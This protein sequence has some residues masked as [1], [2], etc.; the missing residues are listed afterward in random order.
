MLN[1]KGRRGKL[2]SSGTI[3]VL[4]F[5]SL[6]LVSAAL[7]AQKDPGPRHGAP[8]AGGP[9]LTLS[10][11]ELDSFAQA[12]LRFAR[13]VSV[14]GTIE[15]GRGLG[16]T[17]NGND[18]AMCHQ[19]PTVGGSSTS[20]SS[21]D[22]PH[23]NPQVALATLHG[24]TNSVPP[25]IA[26]KGP[27][28]A[29]RFIRQ[30]DGSP[31]GQVHGMYTIAGRIDAK[32]CDLRQPDFAKQMADNNLALRIPTPLYGLGLVEST[33]DIALRNNL[34]STSGPRSR[35]GIAGTFNLSPQDGSIMRFGWKA[36]NKSLLMFAAE[37]SSVEEGITNELFPNKRDATPGCTFNATPEDSSHL[38]NPNSQSPN[39]GTAAGTTSEM[40]SDIVNFAMFIRLLAPPKPAPPTE[41]MQKG[42]SLFNQIGCGLCHSPSLETGASVYTSLSDVTYHPYSDFAL[43]HMGP[44]LADGISQAM[45]GPDEFRTAPLWG[46]GKRLFFLHDGRTSDL[47]RAIEEHS[48]HTACEQKENGKPEQSCSSEA[49]AVIANFKALAPSEIQDILNFLR[50]L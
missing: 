26:E 30:P 45:A 17:F 44:G 3:I 41:S 18:C 29:A 13:S 49:D 33:P 16:P 39:V 48:S 6:A 1:K 20:P 15:K 19:Q 24:A 35:L 7:Q 4:L 47:L 28:F 46:I 40:S 12:F 2:K 21:P 14:S 37:A 25:F 22:E 27:T 36:Q 34:E 32:G 11:S 23:P 9:Y 31:D 50:S 10:K 38:Q 8:G 42:A 5:L 43:H